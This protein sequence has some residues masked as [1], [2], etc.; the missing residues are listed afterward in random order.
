MKEIIF[1]ETRDLVKNWLKK[2]VNLHVFRH[3][4]S[5]EFCA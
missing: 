4:I 2:R 5:Y 1:K 3:E